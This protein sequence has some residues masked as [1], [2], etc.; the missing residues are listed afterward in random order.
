M[1][2]LTPSPR[3]LQKQELVFHL[4]L[5]SHSSYNLNPGN[6]LTYLSITYQI[7]TI[8]VQFFPAVTNDFLFHSQSHP[9]FPPPHLSH[10]RLLVSHA[11]FLVLYDEEKSETRDV[12]KEGA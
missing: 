10:S 7:I 9:L 1:G 2:R 8:I 3:T 12:P 11:L 5:I 4:D 6:P